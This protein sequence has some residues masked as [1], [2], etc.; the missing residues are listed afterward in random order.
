MP[1]TTTDAE[2]LQGG[3]AARLF[4]GART[5]ILAS[6]LGLLVFATAASLLVDRAL[7]LDQVGERV[8]ESLTQEVRELRVL[9]E[10]GRNPT[11]GR[12]FGTDVAAIFSVFLERNVPSEGEEFF[13]YVD[14]R[15]FRS[16]APDGVGRELLANLPGLAS[17]NQ[18]RRADVAMPGGEARYL[19]VPVVI[20]GRQRGVFVVTAALAREEEQVTDALTTTAIVSIVVLVLASGIAIL[21]AGRVLAPVRQLTETAQAITESDLTRRIPVEGTDELAELAATFNAMLDRLEEAFDT[22]KEFV[23]DAG[24]E[25]RTPITVIRGHLELLGDDPREREEIVELV[26]DELDRMAR[27]VDELLLLAKAQRQDFLRL[28]DVDLDVLTEELMAKAQ[29]LADRRWELEEIAP[30]RLTAD[31]Q[32]L[33]QALMNLMRNAVEHTGAGDRIALGSSMDDG[34]AR[35]WVEDCGP[36]ISQP[37]RAR[38]FERFARG[39]GGRPASDGA[40]LG[41]AIVK[42]VAEAHGGWVTVDSEPGKGATFAVVVPVEPAS[43]KERAWSAS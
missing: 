40:G 27:M 5:R 30:G 42:A 9:V 19:A 25:L 34:Y 41:L 36:G 4:R 22:Q 18:S 8:D 15:P 17:T 32:R 38:I 43:R 37:D 24:H 1:V 23:A 6:V 26:T 12:P 3:G 31:R 28:E 13:T 11:T 35:L 16:T 14:G 39:R 10:D 2:P 33:T 20:D 29:A 7:L 21:V